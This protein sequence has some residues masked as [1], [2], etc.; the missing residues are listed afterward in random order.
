MF[1]ISTNTSATG[2]PLGVLITSDEQ[3]LTITSGLKMLAETLPDK[4]FMVKV[5]DKDLRLQ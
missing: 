3:Q 1:I 5:Q 2:I 4:T